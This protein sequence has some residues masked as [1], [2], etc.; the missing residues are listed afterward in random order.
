MVRLADCGIQGQGMGNEE[1]C[2]R[3]DLEERV[4]VIGIHGDRCG[5]V[6]CICGS[7]N[8]TVRYSASVAALLTAS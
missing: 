5:L 1:R 4:C 6:Y 7:E 8:L 2:L 3:L